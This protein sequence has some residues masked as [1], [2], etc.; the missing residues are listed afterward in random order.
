MPA[1]SSEDSESTETPGRDDTAERDD[2]AVVADTE[3]GEDR[4]DHDD[5]PDEGADVSPELLVL[6]HPP[7]V[8]D[9]AGGHV[10]DLSEWP[11]ELHEELDRLIILRGVERVWQGSE[12][13]VRSM[14][15][16]DA[17]ECI[18]QMILD[19]S[20]DEPLAGKRV[21]YEIADWPAGFRASLVES[22]GVAQIRFEWSPEGNLVVLS[23]DEDEVDSIFEAMPDPEEI[24]DQANGLEVQDLLSQ[25]YAA[26]DVLYK[27]PDSTGA[28][29]SLA[30]VTDR[31][32][33]VAVPF[34]FDSKDWDSLVSQASVLRGVIDTDPSGLGLVAAQMLE[35]EAAEDAESDSAADSAAD[36]EGARDAASSVSVG[37]VQITGAAAMAVLTMPE[38]EF[39]DHCRSLRARLITLV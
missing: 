17:D 9:E 37:A 11:R 35:D 22:L 13:V 12:M 32:E 2:T 39:V 24:E 15:A 38:D 14:D 4:L 31:L 18:D 20:G 7:H 27:N 29:T 21:L 3:E 25:L 23:E 33:W 30:E 1:I 26:V 28:R 16:P 19:Y 5:E 6:V 34:G 36:G 8:V 10:Y